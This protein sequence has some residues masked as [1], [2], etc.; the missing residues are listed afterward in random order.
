MDPYGTLSPPPRR[1]RHRAVLIGLAALAAAVVANVLFY[2]L[3]VFAL[4]IGA[5]LLMNGFGSNK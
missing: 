2:G 3:V 4:S 5:G 1:S